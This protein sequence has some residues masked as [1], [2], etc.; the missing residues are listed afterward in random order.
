MALRLQTEVFPAHTQTPSQGGSGA[1]PINT[2]KI[3]MSPRAAKQTCREPSVCCAI[4]AVL[5]LG[6]SGDA[7]GQSEPTAPQWR[8]TIDGW[9][10]L[11]LESRPA[12][13]EVIAPHSPGLVHPM[14]F[15]GIIAV[16]AIGALL[17]PAPRTAKKWHG[18]ERR[19][20]LRRSSDRFSTATAC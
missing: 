15:A 18:P 1:M 20:R 4:V 19:Q 10:R 13:N 17:L 7:F 16:I 9:E 11:D 8:R 14:V 2:R 5:A 3:R 6:F 12:A